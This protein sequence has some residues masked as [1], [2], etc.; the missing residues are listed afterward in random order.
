MSEVRKFRWQ[1]EERLDSG[2]DYDVLTG[3]TSTVEGGVRQDIDPE[4]SA[5]L[6]MLGMYPTLDMLVK[7]ADNP[8]DDL[9]E[10]TA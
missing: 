4:V 8:E 3:R 1:N 2:F 6:T 9:Q 7:W 5:L 10:V